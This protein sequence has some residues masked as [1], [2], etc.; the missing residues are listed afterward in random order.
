MKRPEKGLFLDLDGTI[1][2]S[3]NLMHDAYTEFLIH[4][5]CTG[6]Q[7]EFSRLNGPPIN[8]IISTLA[9]FHKIQATESE[10]IAV[11]NGLIEQK[12]LKV[13]P[14]TGTFDLIE[15]AR[16]KN[17]KIAIVTSN[18]SDLAKRWLMR[19]GL[20]QLID[21]IVGG[22]HTAL[23]KPDP[24]PYLKALANIQCDP[25]VSLAVEDSI[26]GATSAISAGIQTFLIGNNQYQELSKIIPVTD[27]I[28]VRNFI[29]NLY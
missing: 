25:T 26:H 27:L 29:T 1:A 13:C 2:D 14:S 7:L 8:M 16:K 5:N 9:K 12:Y 3:I 10:M 18:S 20:N 21:T 6:S 19:V 15:E 24:E 4:Y 23:G 17:F 11:Y 28:S 22:D